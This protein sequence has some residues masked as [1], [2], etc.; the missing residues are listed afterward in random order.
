MRRPLSAN[1]LDQALCLLGLEI[2]VVLIGAD[3]D[4]KACGVALG[5]VSHVSWALGVSSALGL[6]IR[7]ISPVAAAAFVPFTAS[8]IT[9]IPSTVSIPSPSSTTSTTGRRRLVPGFPR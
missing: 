4:G 3:A 7:P 2:A 8:F 6:A 1:R 5:V 9:A